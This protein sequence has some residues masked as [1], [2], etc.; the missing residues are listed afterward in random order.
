MTSEDKL[1]MLLRRVEEFERRWVEA[2][3]RLRADLLSLKAAV[4][5]GMPE[6]QKGVED[7]QI[8]VG[9]EQPKVTSTMC[10]TK[11]SSLDVEPNLAKDVVGTC[12]TTTT[13][14][15]ELV[16]T[17]NTMGA[18]YIDHPDQ[19]KGMLTKCLT[20]C[21]NPDVDFNLTV[22]AVDMGV[23]TSMAPME[24]VRGVMTQSA[25]TMSIPLTIPRWRTP[26]VRQMASPSIWR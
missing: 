20:N 23:T 4:E 22:A 1:D 9:D 21:S 11:C 18:E 12:A 5:S 24:M 25:R 6:V 2:E 19:P 13:T 15:V 26:S 7:L 10:S 8:L 3:R 14:S 17:E 16:V